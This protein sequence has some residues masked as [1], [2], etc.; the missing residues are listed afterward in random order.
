MKVVV[1][2]SVFKHFVDHSVLSYTQYDSVFSFFFKVLLTTLSNTFTSPSRGMPAEV[3][4]VDLWSHQSV[5]SATAL[6]AHFGI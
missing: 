5:T 2:V 1:Q 3:T 4:M 6:A